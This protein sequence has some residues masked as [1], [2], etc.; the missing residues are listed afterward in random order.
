VLCRGDKREHNGEGECSLLPALSY[1][2][3]H[4]DSTAVSGATPGRGE[5]AEDEAKQIKTGHKTML[6]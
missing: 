3:H 5:G 2:P 4:T 6:E 1:C